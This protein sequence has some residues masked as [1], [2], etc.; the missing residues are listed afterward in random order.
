MSFDL[1]K[2]SFSGGELAP[3]L[4]GRVDLAKFHNGVGKLENFTVLRHG[5]ISNRPG[6]E[7]LGFT[8]YDDK[9]TN[10]IPFI[11]SREES[12]MIEAGEEYFRFFRLGKPIESESGV[13]YEVE[14]FYPAESVDSIRTAQSM[15]TLFIACKDQ[16]PSKLIRYGQTAWSFL[17]YEN[18]LGPF[19]TER[20]MENHL[21]V[22]TDQV[23]LQPAGSVTY[24][25]AG[26]HHFV[27]PEGVTFVN[28]IV[29]GATAG[30]YDNP[31]DNLAPIYTAPGQPSRFASVVARG[32]G[33]YGESDQGP[34]TVVLSN[35]E[36][37][38][39]GETLVVGQGGIPDT[40]GDSW[41][42][43]QNGYVQIRWPEKLS[44]QK[45]GTMTAKIEIFNE[46]H[47]GSLWKLRQQVPSK[48]TYYPDTIGI[49][50]IDKWNVE[51]SGYWTGTLRVER[52]NKVSNQWELIRTMTSKKDRNYSESGTLDEPTMIRI[53][54]EGYGVGLPNG[55]TGDAGMLGTAVL[56]SGATTY[57]GVVKVIEYISPTVVKVEIQ[58]EIAVEDTWTEEWNEGT[59]GLGMGY[60]SAV[61]FYDDRLAFGGS[62]GEPLMV[63]MSRPGDYYN[64]GTSLPLVESD[65]I[66]RR[67][68]SRWNG[69]INALVPMNQLLALTSVNEFRISSGGDGSIS[70]MNFSANVQ[71]NNGSAEIDPVQIGNQLLYVRDGGSLLMEM[72]Y[73]LE[74][75]GYSGQDLTILASHLFKD[76]E[77]VDIAFQKEP[78]SIV[79]VVRKD[80]I[81][82]GLTFMR[83]QEIVAW[84]THKTDGSFKKVA[85]IPNDKGKEEVYFIIERE[86]NGEIKQCIER[87]TERLPKGK[88]EDSFFVDSG[89]T[90][91]G[92]PARNIYPL[93][94]LA[95]K[96]VAILADGKVH[97]KIKVEQYEIKQGETISTVWGIELDHPAS[98]VHVGLGYE[99]KIKNLPLEIPGGETL[100]TKKKQVSG[101]AVLLDQ[102][103]GGWYSVDGSEEQEM[104]FD[105]LGV[106]LDQLTPLFTGIA[107]IETGAGYNNRGEVMITQKDPLPLTILSIIPQ[108]QVGG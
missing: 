77:I 91:R 24:S 27:P 55:M 14:T 10:L 99:S 48:K 85:V 16:K 87:M 107:K 66:S 19:L 34:D 30:Y 42:R 6:T 97:P 76:S 104:K 23:V 36:I 108:V 26:T 44:D 17:E 40:S 82:L 67:I 31:D 92:E 15:D 41:H 9:K 51:T 95:G 59:W 37:N 8:K 25:A 93:D 69:R 73:S 68:I 35:V 38:R 20:H 1:P 46:N 96:E 52:L 58:K 74:A 56:E 75:D 88:L 100:Q 83:E 63:W 98:V 54:G 86:I 47:V 22:K 61:T 72:A 3:T 53:I 89:V 18:R 50:V 32:Q 90:Y 57:D 33:A 80:G 103:K 94:H 71:G 29:K 21:K 105:D 106:P 84:H 4:A 2:P 43:G 60:P 45:F 81:L 64:H 79:W 28:I 78:D 49:K 65:A 12:Y 62:R 70:P 39:S 11:F 7:F 102:S 13:P 101:I 5:G